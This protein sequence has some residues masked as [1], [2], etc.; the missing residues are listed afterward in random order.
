MFYLNG[1][2][3]AFTDRKVVKV[4]E[5]RLHII[6]W[7]LDVKV[8]TDFEKN[9]FDMHFGCILTF[10]SLSYNKQIKKNLAYYL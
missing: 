1:L 2:Y 7:T 10:T 9:D 3:D 5:Q 6:N 8:C 4:L